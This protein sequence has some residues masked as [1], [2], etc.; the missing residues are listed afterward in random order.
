MTVEKLLT[1][2]SIPLSHAEFIEWFAYYN[3]KADKERK[4]R[5]SKRPMVR[6]SS[7]HG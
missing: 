3:V 7:R 6:R 2:K 4:E 1:G 5:P